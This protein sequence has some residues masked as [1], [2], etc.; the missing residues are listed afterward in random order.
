MSP[1]LPPYVF[2][3]VSVALNLLVATQLFLTARA[4][5]WGR[6]RPFAW[7]ALT[8][9]AYASL[10][11]FVALPWSPD[12][13][14]GT[15]VGGYLLLGALNA[16]AWVWFARA[17]DARRWRDLPRS[18]S[19]HVAFVLVVIAGVAVG[20]WAWRRFGLDDPERRSRFLRT[21]QL[22][23]TFVAGGSR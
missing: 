3:L 6:A 11:T 10:F 13:P 23:R 19:R 17:P 18:V 14:V 4:P 2:G 8:A 22:D 16:A 7:V 21:G 1:I 15:R 5:G 12:V 20:V 9:F